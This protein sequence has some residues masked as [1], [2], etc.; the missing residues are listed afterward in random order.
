M[1][2]LT[3]LSFEIFSLPKKLKISDSFVLKFKPVILL[4]GGG[5]RGKFKIGKFKSENQN[6]QKSSFFF[7]LF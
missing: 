6:I 3:M 1:L 7:D 2:F 5:A 4:T